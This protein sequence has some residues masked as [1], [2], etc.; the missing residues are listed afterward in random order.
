MKIINKKN[1]CLTD[2]L[3]VQNHYYL[4]TD[5]TRFARHGTPQTN[6]L[7]VFANLER[8]EQFCVTVGKSLPMFMPVKV[9]V[10][11]FME[12]VKGIGAICVAEGLT[13]RVG[14]IC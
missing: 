10:E 14:T 9:S 8:A 12:I 4:L 1:A 3:L 6:G 13:V 7:L 11:E 5:G 2:L